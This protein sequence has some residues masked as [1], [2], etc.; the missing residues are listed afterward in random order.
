MNTETNTY[1]KVDLSDC[2]F[3]QN[4]NTLSFPLE[5]ADEVKINLNTA[6]DKGYIEFYEAQ[7]ATMLPQALSFLQKHGVA[8]ILF[9]NKGYADSD[10]R[11]DYDK[12]GGEL[13]IVR[14]KYY[15]ADGKCIAE[16]ESEDDYVYVVD[17]DG[18]ITGER[19][20][21][22]VED[23][24]KSGLSGFL[25]KL[26]GDRAG[27]FEFNVQTGEV[28]PRGE[29]LGLD[30]SCEYNDEGGYYNCAWYF[31]K[32]NEPRLLTPDEPGT[33]NGEGN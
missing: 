28:K 7:G 29:L 10:G 8:H 15:D 25:S 26:C 19:F 17:E 23:T 16:Q 2:D 31:W 27:A 4:G 21:G 12:P 18:D 33:P 1:I 6:I 24:E 14:A 3:V 5:H 11:I 30:T 20:D 32:T 13:V 22:D 9:I